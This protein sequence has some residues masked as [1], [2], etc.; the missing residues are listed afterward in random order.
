ME[1]PIKDYNVENVSIAEALVKL[2]A[3]DYRHVLIGFEQV[4]HREGEKRAPISLKIDAGTLGNVVQRLCQAD[5]RYEYQVVESPVGQPKLKGFMIEVRP[6]GA[7]NNPADILNMRVGDYEVDS[8]ITAA[9]AISRISQDAPELREYLERKAE[10]WAQR[11]GTHSG[12]IGAIMS[13]NMVPPRFTLR[14]RDV[15]VRQILDAISLKSIEIY[16]EEPDVD[17][18]GMRGKPYPT[19]WRYNFVINPDASTGIGGIPEWTAL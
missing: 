10:E 18:R 7:V 9:G 19:G 2:R 17:S 1:T 13:G 6:R 5:P 16:R 14:L 12:E 4:P 11:K 3:Q 15:T 8:N